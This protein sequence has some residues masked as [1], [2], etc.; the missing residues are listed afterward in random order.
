MT[1]LVTLE[2]TLR[3][4]SITKRLTIGLVMLVL[5]AGVG[6]ARASTAASSGAYVRGVTQ[7][8]A[9][10]LLFEGSHPI[11]TRAGALAVARDIRSSSRRRLALVAAVPAP[12]WER[13]PA[14]RWILLEHRLA[15]S[16]ALNYVRIY[17]L[18]AAPR[19]TPNDTRRAARLLAKL[20]HAPD[21]IRKSAARLEQRM[22]LPDCTGGG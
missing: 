12:A 3:R 1:S 18:I 14:A 5:A 11:G 2:S 4:R 7:V 9:D 8:C 10:A 20:L 16:Y 19:T 17:D 15:D 21:S 13:R 22:G 6:P